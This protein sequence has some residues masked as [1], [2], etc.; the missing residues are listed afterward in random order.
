MNFS[1][2]HL[3]LG[4]AVTIAV[5]IAGGFWYVEHSNKMRLYTEAAADCRNGVGAGKLL[6]LDQIYG[7]DARPDPLATRLSLCALSHSVDRL[8]YLQ[9]LRNSLSD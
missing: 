6:S 4:G 9:R 7:E 8:E 5:L 1:S 3:A 2:T